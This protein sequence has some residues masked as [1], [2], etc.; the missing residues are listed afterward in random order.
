MVP[1][2]RYTSLTQQLP[3]VERSPPR[4]SNYSISS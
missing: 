2:G 1:V 4:G 3:G